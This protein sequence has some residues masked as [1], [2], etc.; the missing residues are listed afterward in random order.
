MMSA[1][2]AEFGT[3]SSGFSNVP[4][5]GPGRLLLLSTQTMKYG[6]PVSGFFAGA[7]TSRDVLAVAIRQLRCTE[8]NI[9]SRVL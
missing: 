2:G 4:V 3:L 9:R 7:N 5:P 6:L 8:L 1:P